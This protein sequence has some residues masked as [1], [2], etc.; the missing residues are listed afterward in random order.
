MGM[1]WSESAGRGLA[2]PCLCPAPGLCRGQRGVGNMAERTE[3]KR[4]EL[5][6]GHGMPEVTSASPHPCPYAARVARASGDD[7]CSGSGYRE[8]SWHEAVGD[9][10]EHCHSLLWG[11]TQRLPEQSF[12]PSLQP[13]CW[14]ALWVTH[15]P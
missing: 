9:P 11:R 3:Q 12:S 13:L 1:A 4:W 15:S 14:A 6:L 8:S 5:G 2:V 7:A 10:P